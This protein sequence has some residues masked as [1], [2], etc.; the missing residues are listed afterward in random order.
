MCRSETLKSCPYLVDWLKNDDVK[1][2]KK[3]TTAADKM[4]F[5]RAMDLVQSESGQ[6]PGLMATNSGV[7]CSKMIDFVDSYYVLYQEVIE[8]AKDIN[9]KSQA[10]AS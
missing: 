7:F 3:I 6:V 4:K 5:I 8:C 10:L 2:F 9:E 1:E